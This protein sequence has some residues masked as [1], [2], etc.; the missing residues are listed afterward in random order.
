MF[1][2][3]DKAKHYNLLIAENK[4]STKKKRVSFSLFQADS[5]EDIAKLRKLRENQL[6]NFVMSKNKTNQL[7]ASTSKDKYKRSSPPPK[8]KGILSNNT[9]LNRLKE[10][11]EQTSKEK[12]DANIPLLKALPP[13]PTTTSVNESVQQQQL[14]QQQQLQQQQQR[15]EQQQMEEERQRKLNEE[16]LQQQKDLER[17]LAEEAAEALRKEQEYQ[18]E[19]SRLKKLREEE[20]ERIRQEILRKQK[21]EE[22]RIQQEQELK[23]KQL[24]LQANIS[25]FISLLSK[26]IRSFKSQRSYYFP[27]L[28]THISLKIESQ[29]DAYLTP[30]T[31]DPQYFDYLSTKQRHFMLSHIMSSFIYST[32][33]KYRKRMLHLHNKSKADK[34]VL[35]RQYKSKALSFGE[36][37]NFAHKQKQWLFKIQSELC[38]KLMWSCVDSLKLYVNY[39]KIKEYLKRRKTKRLFDALRDNQMLSLELNKTAQRVILIFM[40]KAFFKRMKRDVLVSQGKEVNKKIANEFRKQSLMKKSFGL[41]KMYYGVKKEK[42]LKNRRIFKMKHENKKYIN[43]QVTRK[44]TVKY[45]GSNTSKQ[46]SN[47]INII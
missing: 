41:L 42:D 6:N 38:K 33:N 9:R 12:E 17:K 26:S 29:I 2:H 23:L 11:T 8:P 15:L 16:K 28:L 25:T 44:E 43:I 32:K 10:A 21:E 24:T 20:E 22:E 14:E 34:Y 4:K 45:N 27:L 3:Y 19:Q 5:F 35:Y 13:K 46:I 1:Q 30:E 36:L 31:S 37:L 39:R 40:Y 18:E 47:K 7:R